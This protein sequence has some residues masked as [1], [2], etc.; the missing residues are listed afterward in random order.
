MAAA[1]IFVLVSGALFNRMVSRSVSGLLKEAKAGE[2]GKKFFYSDLEG[3]PEPVQRYFRNVLPEGQDLARFVRLK[4]KAEMRLAEGQKWVPLEAEQYFT[5]EK[6]AF[7]W[8][9]KAK[10]A[11][12]LWIE[13]RDM[14]CHGKGSMFVKLFSAITLANSTGR[15]MDEA[16]LL[17][18]LAEAP[19]FPTALLP[20]NG[21]IRWEPVD[22]DRARVA[23]KDGDLSVWAV[24][25]FNEPGEIIRM[26]S[27]RY[28]SNEKKKI[29][30]TTYYS[31]YQKVSGVKIPMEGIAEWNFEDRDF[32]YF[33]GRITD[34]QHELLAKY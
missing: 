9:A 19:W 8:H 25:H 10:P 32:P 34:I 33:K 13:V 17:R 27:I 14:Y 20:L 7:V 1:V 2:A 3:L 16:S 26:E 12:V 24:V 5:T 21:N 31:D 4:Q 29:K 15:E 18:Y 22:K 30:Y 28:N 11:P 6:P 23:I